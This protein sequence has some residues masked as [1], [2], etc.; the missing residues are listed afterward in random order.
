MKVRDIMSRDVQIARPGD[1]IQDVAGRMASGGFGFMPV[2]EGR[3]V[4][5]VVTDRD[6]VLRALA[7]GAPPS[8]PVV[9]VMTRDVETR[10]DDDDL[11]TVLDCMGS[12]QIRR[13]PI[14]DGE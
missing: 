1:A 2:C 10:R 13:L 12:R 4:V 11:K 9:E 3:D 8:T 5:G 14:L 7:R 6:L